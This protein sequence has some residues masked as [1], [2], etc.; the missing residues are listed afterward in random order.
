MSEQ[1]KSKALFLLGL[2]R[3]AGVS[4]SGEFACEDAVRKGKAHLVLLSA[5][6]SRNT[7]KKFHDKCTFYSVPIID[8]PFSK[9]ALGAAM[10]QTARSCVAVCE[11][12][13]AKGIMEV[14]QTSSNV[15][16]QRCEGIDE[17]D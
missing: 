14:L 15:K 10:G 6:A 8:T 9:D 12:G 7:H 13:L 3:K 16:V 4:S 1:K 2:C 5:D 11:P 17:V